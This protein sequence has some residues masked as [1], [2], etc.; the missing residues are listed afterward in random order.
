MLIVNTSIGIAT[1]FMLMDRS[2]SLGTS[3]APPRAT[4]YFGIR[5]LALGQPVAVDVDADRTTI[6][7]GGFS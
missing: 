2:S 6:G 5:V 4:V 3:L 7:T 1:D